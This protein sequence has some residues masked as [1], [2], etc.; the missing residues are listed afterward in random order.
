MVFTDFTDS[1]SAE[2][3][4]RATGRLLDRHLVLFVVMR[5]SELHDIAARRPEE[6]TDVSRAVAASALLRERAIV[7]AR[8][9]RM[10]AD[11]LEAPHDSIGTRLVDSYIRMKQRSL[12]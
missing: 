9:R 3:M 2:L 12:V 4:L 5:D 7:I 6:P 10:G 8:L 11:V 1:T